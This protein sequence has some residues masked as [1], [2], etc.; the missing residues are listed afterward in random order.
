MLRTIRTFVL[1]AL[2]LLGSVVGV[3]AQDDGVHHLALQISDNDPQKMNAL[4]NVAAN[5]ATYYSGIGEEVEIRIVAFNAGLHM[6]R[7]DTSPVLDRLNAFGQSMPNVSFAACGNTIDAMAKREGIEIPIVANAAR[8]PAG[9]VE[10]MT[11]D[12]AGWTIIRP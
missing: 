3:A 8:V 2:V 12:E 11:L 1:G 9:V 6:L 5:V 4:L 10:L 7:G